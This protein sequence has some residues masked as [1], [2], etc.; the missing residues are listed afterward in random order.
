MIIIFV[1]QIKL[2]N[3][4]ELLSNIQYFHDKYYN[5]KPLLIET[6]SLSQWTNKSFWSNNN[7]LSKYGNT[8]F[9]FGT[10]IEIVL[11]DGN[12][13]RNITLND[14]LNDDNNDNI[15]NDEYIFDRVI[16]SDL[17]SSNK[18][19]KSFPLWNNVISKG[20]VF[21]LSKL[22][23]TGSGTAFHKHGNSFIGLMYGR[24]Q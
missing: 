23:N 11:T 6:S 12:A 15:N 3:I 9:Q 8:S 2:I 1:I 7:L 10:S 17:I 13:I 21:M 14:Y 20:A 5:K 22:N 24:K 4:N 16:W 19:F 18:L